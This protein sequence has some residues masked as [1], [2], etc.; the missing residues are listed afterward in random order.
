[1]GNGSSENRVVSSERN[2]KDKKKDTR[3]GKCGNGMAYLH[4]VH[5][6]HIV[7]GKMGIPGK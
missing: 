4:A 6:V 5:K 2:E 1:M 7:H 3:N